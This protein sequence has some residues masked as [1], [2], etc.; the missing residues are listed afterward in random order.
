[1]KFQELYT[2]ESSRKLDEHTISVGI[3][4]AA[5]MEAA[6][7]GAAFHIRLLYP[8]LEHAYIFTGKGNNG[9]DGWVV[10]RY[11][12]CYGVRV[13]I[14]HTY[15]LD[16]LT[17]DAALHAKAVQNLAKIQPENIRI[18]PYNEDFQ[19]VTQQGV[20][21]DALLGTGLTTDVR[22][23]A[24]RVIQ[25][26]NASE[27]PIISM[28]VPSGLD[29]TTGCELGTAVRATHT[30]C[31]GAMKTGVYLED[32]PSLSGE[33][34]LVPLGLI[35]TPPGNETRRFLLDATEPL[36]RTVNARRHKYES[37]VVYVA[38]GSPGMVGAA[39]MAG[40]AAWKTGCGA[41]FVLV[42]SR[43][44]QLAEQ[45]APELII[46]ARNGSSEDFL[47]A[48][49]ADFLLEKLKQ[50][51]GTVLLGPG[52]GRNNDTQAF[53]QQFLANHEQSA[54]IDADALHYF[55]AI[56]T[57]CTHILTPHPGELRSILGEDLQH[58][59]NRLTKSE[60]FAQQSGN[61]IVSKGYP[62]MVCTS[63]AQSWITGYDTKRFN[64]A[65]FG[66][67]LSGSIAG[68]LSQTD[69]KTFS[70]LKSLIDGKLAYDKARQEGA[71]FPEPSNLI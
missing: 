68:N 40:K 34:H 51:A 4:G 31:F 64:R 23:D 17:P 59:W 33:C 8:D 24:A 48:A 7:A 6:G 1:M 26:M 58:S 10:G 49:D 56:N 44:I 70:C 50:R 71:L 12:A 27:L 65:G 3:P 66:D 30:I 45:L 20:L 16:D 13:Q 18:Q 54:V 36:A 28:D 41:V 35:N 19:P 9:G 47:N 21:I 67:I 39:I 69:D 38:G 15:S 61:L 46:L 32:G 60:A 55:P 43:F 14:I 5:L 42:P 37:G 2:S 22:Q 62:T 25:S 57:Q 29:A 11:L 53:V 52:L 63:T